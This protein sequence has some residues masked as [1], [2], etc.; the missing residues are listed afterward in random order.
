MVHKLFKEILDLDKVHNELLK[1]TAIIMVCSLDKLNKIREQEDQL[2][3]MK[4]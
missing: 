3:M 1:T 2:K 4:N